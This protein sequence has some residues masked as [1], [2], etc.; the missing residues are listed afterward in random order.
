MNPNPNPFNEPQIQNT[1]PVEQRR[2]QRQL[3]RKAKKELKNKKIDRIKA[4]RREINKTF[5]KKDQPQFKGSARKVI[6]Q[7]SKQNH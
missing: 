1:N 2:E 7:A 6:N 5:G 4:N 3:Q